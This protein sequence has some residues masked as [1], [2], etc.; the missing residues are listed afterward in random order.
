MLAIDV[1]VQDV[2]KIAGA[3]EVELYFHAT[4]A[5]GGLEHILTLAI[6]QSL[7][8]LPEHVTVTVVEIEQGGVLRRLQPS[9]DSS[10]WQ[11]RLYQVSYEVVPPQGVDPDTIMQAADRIAVANSSEA[12]MFRQILTT[13]NG[14]AEVG[15]VHVTTP[16]YKVQQKSTGTSTSMSAE[17]QADQSGADSDESSHFA[18]VIGGV[19]GFVAIL[20]AVGSAILIKRKMASAASRIS[21]V[22]D[23]E[24][25]NADVVRMVNRAPSNTLLQSQAVREAWDAKERR[26]AQ[27]SSAQVV[28][29]TQEEEL[30]GQDSVVPPSHGSF[31]RAAVPWMPPSRV[32]SRAWHTSEDDAS[33]TFAG[34]GSRD[35]V[36]ARMPR[37]AFTASQ[38][39]P[40]TAWLV[41]EE[42]GSIA[43]ACPPAVPL[44]ALRSPLRLL[45]V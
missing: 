20:F 6:S 30:E 18:L 39:R 5:Q 37:E 44:E 35:A 19:T 14:V 12:E 27:P 22:S 8:L 33:D 10:T 7:G 13:S 38:S 2:V 40:G 15:K 41:T 11:K 17:A 34:E 16:A 3:L 36:A 24:E 1:A 28:P 42:R 4:L 23:L 25:E 43:A 31:N 26:R 21:P 32:S 45:D 29:F 9:T